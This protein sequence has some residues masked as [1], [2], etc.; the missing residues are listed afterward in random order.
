MTLNTLKD[1]NNHLFAQIERLGNE[2]LKGDELR[3]EIA[4]GKAIT[5][6]SSQIINNGR[7]VLD[8]GIAMK[9]YQLDKDPLISLAKL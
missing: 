7:L 1:L 5:D 3:A 4:R 8:A 2:D 9:E 6:V